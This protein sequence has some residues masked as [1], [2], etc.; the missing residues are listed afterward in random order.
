M[1]WCLRTACI[2]AIAAIALSAQG[3]NVRNRYVL[4]GE[5]SPIQPGTGLLTV[6]LANGSGLPESAVVNSDGTFEVRSS[7]PGAHEL[8]VMSGD[9]TVLHQETV[10]ITGSNQ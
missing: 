3:L 4:R 2:S 6:E 10:M 7:Q 5:L 8:R 9:R 1:R